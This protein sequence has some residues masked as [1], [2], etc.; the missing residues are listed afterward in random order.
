MKYI[1]RVLSLI[2]VASFAFA[3]DNSG[4]NSSQKSTDEKIIVQTE[5]PLQGVLDVNTLTPAIPIDVNKINQI[6]MTKAKRKKSYSNHLLQQHKNNSSQLTVTGD[7]SQDATMSIREK[8]KNE[9]V[10]NI[11]NDIRAK[12]PTIMLEGKNGK[13]ALKFPDNNNDESN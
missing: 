3:I 8:R 5:Q 1:S 13:S 10:Q 2:I 9:I 6:R 7:D 12:Y 4:S 11:T